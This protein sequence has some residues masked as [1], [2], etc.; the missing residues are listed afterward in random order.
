MVSFPELFFFFFFFYI[1]GLFSLHLLL[2]FYNLFIPPKKTLCTFFLAYYLTQALECFH[3]HKTYFLPTF[4]SLS[5]SH[6]F[7]NIRL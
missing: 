7:K 3:F 4:H 2:F 1:C 6:F 5:L